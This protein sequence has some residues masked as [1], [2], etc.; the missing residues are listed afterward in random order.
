M[1]FLKNRKEF[2]CEEATDHANGFKL[3]TIN[4]LQGEMQLVIPQTR[5]GGFYPSCLEKGMRSVG[6]VTSFL[7]I[8]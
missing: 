6:Y 3:R 8:L 1:N 5:N 4:T 7:Q 2:Q